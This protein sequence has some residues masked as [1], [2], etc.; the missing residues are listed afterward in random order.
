MN[1]Y[2]YSVREKERGKINCQVK[3]FLIKLFL[4]N[5]IEVKNFVPPEI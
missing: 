2:I 5:L 3:L 4:F 1:Y